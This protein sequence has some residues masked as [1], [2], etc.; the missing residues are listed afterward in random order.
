[1]NPSHKQKLSIWNM[2]TLKIYNC[3]YTD[4]RVFKVNI[5]IYGYVYKHIFVRRD[6]PFSHCQKGKVLFK[7]RQ[8][9]IQTP[10]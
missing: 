9:S 6:L 5:H 2:K 8:T 7:E 4:T 1:M 3:A 10:F